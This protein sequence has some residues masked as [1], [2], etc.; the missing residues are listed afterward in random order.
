MN[1]KPAKLQTMAVLVLIN[2][3]LNIVWGGIL[4]LLG[5]LSLIGILCAP[6]LLL[7]MVLGVFE[8]I[9]A[10][11]LLADPPRV[12]KLSQAIAILE[13]CNFL[14]LNIFSVVVGVISLIF[15]NEDE[16]KDYFGSLG[17]AA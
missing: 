15:M 4:A 5:V 6:I 16:I 1:N 9:Y 7:P 10:L 2:G 14:F 3:V 17:P 12:T 11:K 8:L 13:I